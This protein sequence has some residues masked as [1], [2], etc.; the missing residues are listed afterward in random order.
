M[1]QHYMQFLYKHPMIAKPS[2]KEPH[3]WTRMPL[4][5]MNEMHLRLAVTLQN[6]NVEGSGQALTYDAT[7]ST[8]W[9][10]NFLA[11]NRDFCAMQQQFLTFF[12]TLNSLS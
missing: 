1:K 5:N 6:F 3:W 10:S 8:L 11:D 12:H 4:N 9:D 7:T 2:R